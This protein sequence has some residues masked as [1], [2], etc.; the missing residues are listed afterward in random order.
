MCNRIQK[1]YPQDKVFHWYYTR[2]EELQIEFGTVRCFQ[3]GETHGLGFEWDSGIIETVVEQEIGVQQSE[4]GANQDRR[5][6]M[7]EFF[8]NLQCTKEIFLDCTVRKK[9]CGGRDYAVLWKSCDDQVNQYFH[10]CGL[11]FSSE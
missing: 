7:A 3:V 4:A 11:T 8:F 1:F 10:K 5:V 2:D 6:R 9:C